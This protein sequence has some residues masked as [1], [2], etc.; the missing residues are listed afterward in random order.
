MLGDN[1][2]NLILLIICH[3]VPVP[4]GTNLRVNNHGELL[5][6]EASSYY[7]MQV[8]ALACGLYME[9]NLSLNSH[10]ISQYFYVGETT[11]VWG[12]LDTAEFL[13]LRSYVSAII[14]CLSPTYSTYVANITLFD[15]GAVCNLAISSLCVCGN[16]FYHRLRF[17]EIL[18]C[19][20]IFLN[21]VR[22][23]L[24]LV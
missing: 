23:R 11:E 1:E 9:T 13:Y 16:Q 4:N 12:I 8:Q 7:V 5:C 19:L 15:E 10:S 24:L 21:I 22:N 14:R 3:L 20:N 2:K 18:I 6:F 17:I